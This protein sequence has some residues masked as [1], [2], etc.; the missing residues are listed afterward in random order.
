MVTAGYAVWRAASTKAKI[1]DVKSDVAV[2]GIIV[3]D[4]K[5]ANEMGP[6]VVTPAEIHMLPA[7][8]RAIGALGGGV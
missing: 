7:T 4:Q 6:K 5:L 3:N 1:E 2:E 8:A